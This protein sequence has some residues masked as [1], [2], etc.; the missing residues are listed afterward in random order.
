[1]A[2][3]RGHNSPIRENAPMMHERKLT[4]KTIEDLKEPGR[5]LDGGGLYIDVAQRGSKPWRLKYRPEGKEK[6]A[7][8]GAWPGASLEEARQKAGEAREKIRAVDLSRRKGRAK[9]LPKRKDGT[10]L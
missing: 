5:Y 1:M 4:A 7:S 9:K 8:F 2:P 3:M 6:P 10:R